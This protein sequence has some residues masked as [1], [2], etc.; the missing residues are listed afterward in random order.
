MHDPMVVAHEI[1]SP[2]P[3]RV[4][5]RETH[6]DGRRWGFT[7]TLGTGPDNKGKPVYPWWRPKG[8]TLALGG[9]VYGLGS[10][11]TIWHVEP[12][13]KDSGTV[14]RHY[15]RKSDPQPSALRARLS[16]FLKVHPARE[17]PDDPAAERGWIQDRA[18]KWHVHHWR[19]QIHHVQRLQRFLL[20]RCVECGRRYPWGYAP[21]SH[22]WDGPRTRW[23]DGVVHRS[24]H[25]ECSSLVS[26][27]R[28]KVEDADTLKALFHAYQFLTDKDEEQAVND[29]FKMLEGGPNGWTD[30][31]RRARRV[32]SLLGYEMQDSTARWIKAEG[33]ERAW[34]GLLK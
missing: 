13:G 2:I 16:P 34:N 15:V 12:D 30:G 20:E 3:H 32:A 19:I 31:W 24:Y 27:R 23:R 1:P 9:R 26:L 33:R 7:R 14:C 11:A 29:L 6:Y 18:W 21:V 8:W 5:W 22:Q 4:K 28:Q 10:I 25:H 17:V